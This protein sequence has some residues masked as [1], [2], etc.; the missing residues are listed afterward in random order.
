[1]PMRAAEIRLGKANPIGE[2]KIDGLA[3]ADLI[4]VVGPNG[5]G[6]SSLLEPL[7]KPGAAGKVMG[8]DD[9]GSRIE[10]SA[11]GVQQNVAF[12]TS[13]DLMKE[14]RSLSQAIALASDSSRHR[15]EARIL[16]ASIRK[17]ENNPIRP[18]EPPELLRLQ[19]TYLDADAQCDD[20]PRTV[21]RY[22]ELA[23]RLA[24]A[25]GADWQGFDPDST[26]GPQREH[27]LRPNFR[28]LHG[29]STVNPILTS[30]ASLGLPDS[31]GDG[32]ARI[33]DAAAG[34]VDKCLTRIRQGSKLPPGLAAADALGWLKEAVDS[35]DALIDAKDQLVACS[36]AALEYLTARADGAEAEDCPVCSQSIDPAAVRQRLQEAV[37]RTV[38]DVDPELAELQRQRCLHDGWHEELAGL[39][40]H[41]EAAA[42]SADGA[43][44][45]HRETLRRLGLSLLVAADWHSSVR[46]A[47]GEIRAGIDRWLV[48]HPSG[49]SVTAETDL[50][51]LA[52]RARDTEKDLGATQQALAD[53]H[54]PLVGAFDDLQRLGRLLRARKALND[55]V[56]VVD[57][58]EK[59]AARR[60]DTRRDA[61]RRVLTAMKAARTSAAEEAGDRAL[62]SD[63]IRER[64]TRLMRRFADIDPWLAGLSYDGRDAG[65]SGAASHGTSQITDLSE[66][67]TVLVNLAAALTV[68]SAVVGKEGH[69][70]RWIVLDEPTNALDST[71]VERVADYLGSLTL[72]DLPV[73]IFVATFD[74]DFAQRLQIG[75]LRA[76]R[77]VRRIDLDR[78]DRAQR[79]LRRIGAETLV[80]DDQRTR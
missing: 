42:R 2:Q 24:D 53:D 80:P 21:E 48:N 32:P 7:R 79:K 75:A 26:S 29:F 15:V 22:E 38:E 30:M 63:A 27:A 78:F 17:L 34:A 57:P 6:K 8:V 62:A 43:F 33:A 36:K 67:Q 25:A 49:A 55:F 19:A 52:K 58:D 28:G 31:G 18:D 70:P 50:D 5:S 13:I 40:A 45:R 73:Q 59:D 69:T 74:R 66:G 68:A 47:A 10:F 77:Q 44:A 16:E 1:M 20:L 60:R 61:W 72:E 41:R 65:R 54:A 3:Q 37:R 12:I 71:A 11:A 64:F 4:L 35:V 76:G 46:D 56:H 39:V 51:L 14:I 23:R 9:G